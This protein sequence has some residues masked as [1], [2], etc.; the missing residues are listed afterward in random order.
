MGELPSSIALVLLQLSPQAAI[1]LLITLVLSTNTSG[2]GHGVKY[3]SL[4]KPAAVFGLN[5]LESTGTFLESSRLSPTG[6][7]SPELATFQEMVEQKKF[8]HSEIQDSLTK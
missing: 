2:I 4:K 5:A 1:G 7:P 8:R 3:N 6:T